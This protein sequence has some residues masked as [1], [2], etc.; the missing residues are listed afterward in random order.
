MSESSAG[1]E[2]ELRVSPKLVIAVLPV[3][4][5][6]LYMVIGAP[7]SNPSVLMDYTLL[8]FL[9]CAV[10]AASWQLIHWN[11]WVGRWFTILALIAIVHLVNAR[12]DVPGS[13]ALVAI[14]VALSSAMI[15]L[16]AATLTAAGETLLL[17]VLLRHEALAV[18]PPAGVVAL[19]AIWTTLGVMYAVYQPV[20][21]IAQ[22]SWEYFERTQSLLEEARDRQV[23][24]KQVVDDLAHA[25]LQLTRL[26][27]LAQRLRQ[28]AED[29]RTSKER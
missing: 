15:N 11:H 22:W 29:A 21:R 24:L 18:D 9:L 1:F 13:L 26:N 14:P 16:G 4:G 19:V 10:S 17:I 7:S 28:A 27:I 20:R 3:L 2:S 6:V 8:L 5:I 12:L 23:E 25:N